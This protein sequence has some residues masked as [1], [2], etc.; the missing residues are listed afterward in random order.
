M[1]DPPRPEARTAIVSSADGA[2]E[3]REEDATR[4]QHARYL[5]AGMLTMPT[6]TRLPS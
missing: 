2:G 1:I 6:A 4:L 3:P 5:A